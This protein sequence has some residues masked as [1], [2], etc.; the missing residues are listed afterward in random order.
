[1]TS[2]KA[3]SL[4]HEEFIS[5]S[6]ECNGTNDEIDKN[7]TIHTGDETII[8]FLLKGSR[9]IKGNPAIRGNLI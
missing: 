6:D 1:M 4:S 2:E 8:D 9:R 3:L 5:L 7:Q